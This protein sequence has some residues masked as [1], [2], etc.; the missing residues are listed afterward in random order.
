MQL[1][2]PTDLIVRTQHDHLLIS[3]IQMPIARLARI[4]P[5]LRALN[6][7]PQLTV[8]IL[9]ALHRPHDN[10][11]SPTERTNL[12]LIDHHPIPVMKGPSCRRQSVRILD[13]HES[14][15]PEPPTGPR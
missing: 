10:Q 11:I 7:H 8:V 4:R 3:R 9:A 6:P 15:S 14:E 2:R 1:A 13:Y 12:P 5:V